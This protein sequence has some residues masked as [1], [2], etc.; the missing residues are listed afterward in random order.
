MA[1]NSTKDP[2]FM[3]VDSFGPLEEVNCAI[4]GCDRTKLVTVQDWFGERFH[5]VRCIRCKLMFT[6]PRP[7]PEWRER[8]Y[9]PRHNPAMEQE[10]RDFIYLGTPDRLSAYR[11]ILKFLKD[12]I[13]TSTKLLD[14]GCAAGQ[15]V[16]LAIEEGFDA[17][18]VDRSPGAIAYAYEHFGL[19]LILAEAENIPVPDSTYD[20]VTLHHVFE[21]FENPLHTLK[22][23]KRIL[24]PGGAL[25][26]ETPNYLRF[27]L[28]EKYFFFL[29]PIYLKFKSNMDSWRGDIPWFPF[30]HYYHWTPKTLL[31]ALS[32]A[33]FINNQ[34]HVISNYR[35][36]LPVDG[37]LRSLHGLAVSF[38][39]SLFRL[40][41]GRVNLW[42]IL[43][44]TAVKPENCQECISS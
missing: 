40:T 42:G 20:V 12:E 22:E 9:D 10:K 13:R 11:R 18:G 21:H 14:V 5:V 24:K 4:C 37:S 7:T 25:F 3:D 44:A 36:G 38:F 41:K 30:D 33:G 32:K 34:T 39:G 2:R 29:K 17:T 31:L 19:E 28:M 1:R 8:F 6:N 43:A 16:Q 26:I 27:Y 15:F 35:H 23:I